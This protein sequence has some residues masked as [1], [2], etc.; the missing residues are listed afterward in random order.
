MA[1][2]QGELLHAGM[3]AALLFPGAY[4]VWRLASSRPARGIWRRGEREIPADSHELTD[5]L[6]QLERSLDA[7]AIEVERIGEG[8]RFMTRLFTEHETPR[9]PREDGRPSGHE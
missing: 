5:R 3:H 9:A 6:T 8:Q 1:V 4:I 7:A 2:A